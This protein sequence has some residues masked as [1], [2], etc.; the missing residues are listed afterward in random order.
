MPMHHRLFPPGRYQPW[1]IALPHTDREPGMT[2]F[3][4]TSIRAHQYARYSS[5]PLSLVG[6]CSPSEWE[7]YG[8]VPDVDTQPSAG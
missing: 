5:F 7:E 3:R 1:Q 8:S 2:S 4:R 6:Y